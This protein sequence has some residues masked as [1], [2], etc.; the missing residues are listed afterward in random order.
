MI[1]PESAWEAV[2]ALGKA[3]EVM[4]AYELEKS[5]YASRP[6]P[7]TAPQFQGA[8]VQVVQPAPTIEPAQQTETAPVTIH[9]DASYTELEAYAYTGFT[10]AGWRPS[11]S[12]SSSS[13]S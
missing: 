12:S 8:A 7:A 10:M 6:G 1:C 5:Y 11:S 9:T 3:S 4:A 13:S 2:E